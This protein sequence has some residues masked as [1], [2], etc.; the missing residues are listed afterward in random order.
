MTSAPRKGSARETPDRQGHRLDGGRPHRGRRHGVARHQ[1]RDRCR[2]M[3]DHHHD[4]VR[5][6]G[7]VKIDGAA[8]REL[9][10]LDVVALKVQPATTSPAPRQESSHRRSRATSGGARPRFPVP[11]D[12]E[13]PQA[14]K[15]LTGFVR[16]AQPLVAFPTGRHG[17]QSQ[18]PPTT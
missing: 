18:W 13:E 17:D 16:D 6:P 15:S 8:S 12:R 10:H 2:R 11:L 5:L 14:P 3:A 4:G 9:A 7:R 1:K